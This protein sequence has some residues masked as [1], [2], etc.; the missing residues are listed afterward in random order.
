[1]KKLLGPKTKLLN[2]STKD[3][4]TTY[5]IKIIKKRRKKS[6]VNKKKISKDSN[7]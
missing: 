6:E 5:G 7:N 1:M 4:I 3:K 2:R